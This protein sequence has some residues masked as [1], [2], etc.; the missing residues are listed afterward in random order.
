MTE[1]MTGGC[2]CG[3]VRY[4]I[5]RPADKII[6]CHCTHCQKSSGSGASFNAAMPADAFA[7]TQGTPKSYHDTA[8]SGNILHRYF[9]GDC[10]SPLYSLVD[11]VPGL[12]FLKAGTLD[13]VS[14]LV[15]Q[16]QLWCATAQPWLTLDPALPKFDYNP[17]RA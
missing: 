9:C 13:E 6:A 2:L 14:G 11:A 7:I 1:A 17:P 8:D 4:R 12:A 10:G 15:P 3:A 16:V 5:T